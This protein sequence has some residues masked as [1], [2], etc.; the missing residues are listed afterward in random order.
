MEFLYEARRQ[1]ICVEKAFCYL[2]NGMTL[3][4]ATISMYYG[5]GMEAHENES[6]IYN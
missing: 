2:T 4:K 1:E 5:Y 6:F 3:G